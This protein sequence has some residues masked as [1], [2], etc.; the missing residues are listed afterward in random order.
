MTTNTPIAQIAPA[1]ARAQKKISVADKNAINDEHKSRYADLASIIASCREALAEQEI[2]IL[3]P[4]GGSSTELLV[5]TILVHSSGEMIAEEFRIKP[6]NPND[7]DA[8]KGL[9]T[10]W[11]RVGLQ[12]LLCIATSDDDGA[13]GKQSKHEPKKEPVQN[14]GPVIEKHEAAPEPDTA[15]EPVTTVETNGDDWREIVVHVG[16]E[17]SPCRG[18]KLGELSPELLKW[19]HEKV[20]PTLSKTKKDRALAAGIEESVKGPELPLTAPEPPEEEQKPEKPA[21]NAKE[22]A[23]SEPEKPAEEPMEWRSVVAHNFK[24]NPKITLGEIADSKP[25][26][27]AKGYDGA[28]ILRGMKSEGIAKI[29]AK[30][31]TVK[32]KILVNAILAANE[33]MDI[34]QDV[35]AKF[36]SAGYDD[37]KAAAHLV[38]SGVLEDGETLHSIGAKMLGYIRDQWEEIA[39]TLEAK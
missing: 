28:K 32:D 1:L 25:D 30:A 39:K 21:K 7:T 3:Q 16:T 10:Q 20:L 17:T 38:A 31:Q 18:K 5:N 33:E 29:Q 35:L 27:I 15:P 8:V 11:R 14:P 13:T 6:E 36:E 37:E 9:V 4:L 26:E 19:L 34:R 24:P 12:S 22:T 2:S 23:P